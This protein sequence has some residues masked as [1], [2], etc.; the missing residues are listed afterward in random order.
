MGTI[1]G[2]SPSASFEKLVSPMYLYTFIKANLAPLIG[3]DAI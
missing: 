1:I 2:I 3:G